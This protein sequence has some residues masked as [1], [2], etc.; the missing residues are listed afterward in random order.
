MAV[1]K[2]PVT[3]GKPDAA[4]GQG[5]VEID[6]D[7]I[8]ANVYAEALLQG[9]KVMVNRGM[10]KITVANL[11][12]DK[13]EEAK[14]AA[15]AVAAKNVENINAGKIRIV[16]AKSAGKTS[17]A[18]NTEAMRLARNAVKDAMKRENIKVSHVAASTI[19]AAAKAL[20]ATKP[21]LIEKAKAN[22]AE[23]D[24]ENATI[25]VDTSLIVEDP[26]KVAAA[27]AKKK[28]KPLSAAKA[29]Q[30]KKHKPAAQATA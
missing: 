12:G 28:D 29:G 14:A 26:K 27:E 11:S 13:L 20:L 25:Q 22:I 3:K 15:M 23:R 9:L 10:S 6:T 30:V 8:P 21:E 1:M 17:G 7:A 5:F 24:A 19:T 16:G 2:V 4:T 18:V